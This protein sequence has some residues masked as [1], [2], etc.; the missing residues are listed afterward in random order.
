M[1]IH[2]RLRDKIFRSWVR[3]KEKSEDY[4]PIVGFESHRYPFMGDY[5]RLWENIFP[6]WDI[7]F[8][9]WEIIFR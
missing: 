1:D 7:I 4:I 6:L 2:I 3:L 9:L 5:F 8:C